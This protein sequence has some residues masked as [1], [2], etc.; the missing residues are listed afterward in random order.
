MRCS[1]KLYVVVLL[2]LAAAVCVYL[3]KSLGKGHTNVFSTISRQNTPVSEEP[4][5]VQALSR[6]P[7]TSSPTVI[8]TSVTGKLTTGAITKLRKYINHYNASVLP[9]L[10][11]EL[12]NRIMNLKAQ[13][14]SIVDLSGAVIYKQPRVKID[15]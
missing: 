7:D 12:F 4:V 8:H 9:Q 14:C 10:S 15:Q 3:S 1:V 5:T 6:P 2:L 13:Y 11:T